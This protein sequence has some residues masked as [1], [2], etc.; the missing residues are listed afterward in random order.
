ML[1]Q[2]SM[3]WADSYIAVFDAKYTYNFWRPPTAIRNGDRD[4]NEAT[5]VDSGWAPLIENPMHPEYP[6]AHCIN[7][8]AIAAVLDREFGSKLPVLRSR[9]TSL[10]GVTHTW[11]RLEDLVDEVSNARVWGGVHYRNS[12]AVGVAMGRGIGQLVA[13]STLQPR[14]SSE[15][16]R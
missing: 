10:P 8:G 11:T 7:V 15:A 16:N 5:S 1:A 13:D 14:R 9:S 12:A 4:G 2:A 6:C 3:A